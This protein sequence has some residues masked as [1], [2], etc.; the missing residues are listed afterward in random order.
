MVTFRAG[1]FRAEPVACLNVLA[2]R[3]LRIGGCLAAFMVSPSFAAQSSA[4]IQHVIVIMQ[5]NR[6]FDSYFATFPGADGPPSG[7]CIPLD[8]TKPAS[9][10]VAPFHDPHDTSL[11]GPHLAADAQYDLDDGVTK[12]LQDGFVEEQSHTLTRGCSSSTPAYY[13]N[14]VS[15]LSRHDVM[16]YHTDA[17]IPNYWAYATNFVLQDRMFEGC[18]RLVAILASRPGQR[19]VRHLL[20]LHQDEHLCDRRRLPDPADQP[21]PALGQSVPVARCEQRLLEILHRHRQRA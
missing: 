1:Q 19:V 21:E 17:E 15:E 8:I 18:A 11:G 6:S 4:P 5:E 10:C 14:D 7:T 9:G 13:C 2:P 12:T 3:A 16:G 20:G